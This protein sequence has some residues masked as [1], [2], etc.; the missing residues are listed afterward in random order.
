MNMLLTIIGVIGVLIL[1]QFLIRL[2]R[3]LWHFPA[4]AFIGRFLD[5]GIR[6]AMQ[7]PTKII[8]RSGIVPGMRVLEVGCG[9][10]AYTLFAAEAVG[11]QGQVFALDIQP[12]M[13]KQLQRK[14]EM[15]GCRHLK[16]RVTLVEASAAQLPFPDAAF[17]VVYMISVLQEIP[18]K[19]K[20]LE[21][22]KRVLKPGG[23][24]SISEFIPDP[25]YP[26]SRTTIRD[27]AKAGFSD[28]FV[29]GSL[30][31]YTATGIR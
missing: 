25:D 23:T 30:W 27:L 8:A 13:L 10:G 6:R 20:A 19:A 22:A 3:K 15:D 1:Y 29:H 14:L 24:I 18:G 26:L 12:G 31:A 5:S 4:P 17:D 11:S 2:F 16:A 21:E 9:S 28:T 7:S